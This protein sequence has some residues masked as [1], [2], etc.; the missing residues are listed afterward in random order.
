MSFFKKLL[1]SILI[2]LLLGGTIYMLE[3]VWISLADFLGL[4]GESLG[5][6]IIFYGLIALGIFLHAFLFYKFQKSRGVYVAG[7]G[8]AAVLVTYAIFGVLY[9]LLHV[10]FPII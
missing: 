4:T 8:W 6:E 1:T 3:L 2:F 10:T 9:Y 5:Y 7:Q